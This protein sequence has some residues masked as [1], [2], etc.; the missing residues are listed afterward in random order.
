[1]LSAGASPGLKCC[2][3]WGCPGL[4]AQRSPC[5]RWEPLAAPCPRPCRQ[6]GTLCPAQLLQPG[7]EPPGRAGDAL[8]AALWVL[9][10]RCC[11]WAAETSPCPCFP[12]LASAPPEPGT[13]HCPDM[14]SQGTAGA[15]L[16][17]FSQILFPPAAPECDHG[18]FLTSPSAP[19]SVQLP[20]GV[21]WYRHLPP[22][23]L[24]RWLWWDGEDVTEYPAYGMVLGWEPHSYS[25]GHP[26]SPQVPWGPAPHCSSQI[27]LLP[28]C[29]LV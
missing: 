24:E 19:L 7:E 6:P 29:P 3:A 20:P 22:G 14:L 10:R 16:V 4:S 26:G 5:Q 17:V 23:C 27:L 15:G 8:C 25:C 13:S 11:L 12:P 28:C 18:R 1:M 9:G 2:S 21:P